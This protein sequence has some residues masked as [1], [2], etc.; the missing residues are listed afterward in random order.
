MERT[1]YGAALSRKHRG[2]MLRRS[3]LCEA[4]Q[5]EN[6]GNPKVGGSDP[7]LRGQLN[8]GDPQLQGRQVLAMPF[9]LMS[10]L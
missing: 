9:L 6:N 8:P 7:T 1:I 10:Q 3:L 4:W 5:R 2:T